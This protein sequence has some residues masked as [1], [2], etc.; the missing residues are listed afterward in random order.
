MV[1]PAAEYR[2][3]KTEIDAALARVLTSGRY[4]LGPEGEALERERRTPARRMP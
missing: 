2:A 1:D 3:F 4:I